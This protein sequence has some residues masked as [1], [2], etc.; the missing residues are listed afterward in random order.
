M[1]PVQSPDVTLVHSLPFFSMVAIP[2]FP[3]IPT[4]SESVPA[5]DL[6]FT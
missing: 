5:P 6:I 1:Y 2:L 3:M 4:T